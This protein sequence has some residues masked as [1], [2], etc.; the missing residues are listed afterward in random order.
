[1]VV[2]LGFLLWMAVNSSKR[3]DG[4][5]CGLDTPKAIYYI[6]QNVSGRNR[7]RIWTV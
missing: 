5:S 7:A 1:M 4:I 3:K 2:V 6:S